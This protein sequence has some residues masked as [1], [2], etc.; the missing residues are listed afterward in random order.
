MRKLIFKIACIAG[1]LLILFLAGYLAGMESIKPDLADARTE[2]DDARRSIDSIASRNRDLD[3]GIRESQAIAI[4]SVATITD[5]I[6][7]AGGITDSVKRLRYLLEGIRAAVSELRKIS[8]N[9]TVA[10]SP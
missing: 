3:R 6:N 8:T 10:P 7:K 4:S 9:G 1:V 5:A 2:L